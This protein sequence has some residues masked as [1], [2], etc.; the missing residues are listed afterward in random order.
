MR[1]TDFRLQFSKKYGRI[2]LDAEYNNLDMEVVSKISSALAH[3]EPFGL[4]SEQTVYIFSPRD[5]AVVHWGKVNNKWEKQ[6]QFL[7]DARALEVF[8]ST[9]LYT[10]DSFIG[11]LAVERF[12]IAVKVLADDKRI[13]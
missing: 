2:K 9:C 1:M 8:I 6:V 3:N 7:P 12:L 5:L 4:D 13:D 10:H 11:P